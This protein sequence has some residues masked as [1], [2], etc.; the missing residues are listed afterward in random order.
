MPAKPPGSRRAALSAADRFPAEER[1]AA[2][3][4]P[5]G[6]ATVDRPPPT[7]NTGQPRRRR[8]SPPWT[9]RRIT[10][11]AAAAMCLALTVVSASQ[12]GVEPTRLVE[13]WTDMGNLLARM[14]PIETPDYARLA[15]PLLDTIMMAV[16]GTALALLLSVPLAFLAAG[17]TS[18]H[19]AV[20]ALAR[21][22]ILGARSIPD[23]IYALI[24]VRVLGVGV[25]PG[26][27]AI[28]VYSTGMI[29]K[30][31]ADTIEE[32]D[33]GVTQ[34]LTAVGA[35]RLHIIVTGVLPQVMPSF[36][37]VGLYRLDMNV[38]ASAI[39]GFVGAGGI[40]FELYTTLR[41][42]QYQKGLGVALIIIVLVIMV[43][44]LSAVIRGRLITHRDSS[45]WAVSTDGAGRQRLSPPWTRD[46]ITRLGAI[47]T[48]CGLTAASFA[49]LGISP[50]TVL[51]AVPELIAGFADFWPPDFA[52]VASSLPD[53]LLETL[54]IAVTATAIATLLSVPIAAFAARTVAPHP[55]VYHAARFVIVLSRGLPPLLMALIFVSAF[56]LGPFAGAIA[57][58]LATIGMTAK[59]MADAIEH[60]DPGP[61]AAL[62]A[63]G[64]SRTQQ[65]ST[66]VIPQVAPSFVST[67][68]FT[69]DSTIRS[70][71]IVG[72]VGA[73][74]IGFI[75]YQSVHTLQFH[76]TTAV[77]IVI[78]ATVFIVERCAD[79]IR[80][81][82]L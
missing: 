15:K 53:A 60:L 73:G 63:A 50:W 64:A 66:A 26:V 67:V 29:G 55:A 68:L 48:A 11:Y 39:L 8:L 27:L 41:T 54:T 22:V 51:R 5:P 57:L 17:N 58:G 49:G 28:A 37:S 21:A 74:G 72:V 35:R 34:A 44:R 38:A 24:F 33:P 23:L 2:L 7:N 79:L 25:L 31:F 30:L 10:A 18:P 56:G 80:K 52:S 70:S 81:R 12:V 78:F 59:L 1:T 82:I 40:G 76:T 61:A 62:R 3:S 16:T 77:L 9:R 20:R 6:S 47:I 19:P 69:L 71:T 45:V 4:A 14:T 32:V 36:V 46:R 13:G 65:V 43:E 75:T 42:L